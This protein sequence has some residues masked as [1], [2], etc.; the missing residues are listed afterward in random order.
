MAEAV[1]EVYQILANKLEEKGRLE[2]IMGIMSWDQEVV[3]PSGATE[4]RA[5][6]LATLAGVIHEKATDPA[7]GEYVEQLVKA[8]ADYLPRLIY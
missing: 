5:R 8:L 7:I 2:G 1:H 4:S 3:M 6:Q